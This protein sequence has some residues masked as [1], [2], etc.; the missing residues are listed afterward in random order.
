M[1]TTPII[2]IIDDD[3]DDQHL[4]IEAIK[5]INISIKCYTAMTGQEGLTKLKT[6]E[7]PIPTLIF[8]DLNM[9]RIDGRKFLTT[10]KQD[11][12]FNSIPVVI[13]STS[14][15]QMERNEMLQLGAADYIDKQADFSLLKEKLLV[16]VSW[17]K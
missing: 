8:L 4:L 1:N 11:P 14:T 10:I 9:P 16:I 3:P 13:Y 12:D 5:E 17:L 15:N 6:G 7:I 2:Y